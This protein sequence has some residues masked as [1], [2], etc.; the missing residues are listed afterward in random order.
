MMQFSQSCEVNS[1]V[2][3]ILQMRKAE[4]SEVGWLAQVSQRLSKGSEHSA[5]VLTHSTLL[6]WYII[7]PNYNKNPVPEGQLPP[8]TTRVLT[9]FL[10]RG[11]LSHWGP[12]AG[13]LLYADELPGF[14]KQE[15][16]ERGKRLLLTFL[17]RTLH[18]LK[19]HWLPP[20][21]HWLS[22]SLFPKRGLCKS[23][24]PSAG[25]HTHRG[26]LPLIHLH[27]SGPQ[28]PHLSVGLIWNSP[29]MGQRQGGVEGGF[30][31]KIPWEDL[32]EP[33]IW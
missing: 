7:K 19:V 9:L 26:L 13:P 22:G 16:P 27:A 18:G 14:C 28:F 24:G 33:M 11:C 15:R 6:S 30:M 25:Y 32:L 4:N 3:P 17:L 31:G 12:L 8:T 5:R 20:A 2:V 29:Y 1:L 21:P 10:P 23:W